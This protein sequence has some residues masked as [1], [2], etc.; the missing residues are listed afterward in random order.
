MANHKSTTSRAVAYYR[1]STQQQE[2]SI[3]QQREWCQPAAVRERLDVV[4]EFADDGVSGSEVEKRPGLMQLVA[5]CEQQHKAKRPVGVILCWDADRLSRASSIRTA[6]LLDDLMGAGVTH[7]FTSEGWIDLEDDADLLVFNVRQDTGRAAYS[8]SVAKNVTRSAIERAG[9]GFW[10]GGK[11]PYGYAVGADGRLAPV[12]PAASVVRRVFA[13]LLAGDSLHE[14]CRALNAGGDPPPGANRKHRD[15]DHKPVWRRDVVGRM[16][17]NRAYVGELVWNRTH[18]GKHQRVRGGRQE[19]TSGQRGESTYAVNAPEDHVAVKDAH[20]ALIDRETFDA[21]AARLRGA[22]WKNAGPSLASEWVF[23]GLVRCGD[24]GSKMYGRTATPHRSRRVAVYRHYVCSAPGTLGTGACRP[25]R[26]PQDM[27]LAAVLHE[28]R[29][30]YSDP[31]RLERLAGAVAE[32]AARADAS[33]GAG[34]DRAEAE[35][36]EI[37][38]QIRQAEENMVFCPT[39]QLHV[40]SRILD[41]LNARRDEL[42]AARDVL[43]DSAADHAADTAGVQEALA[44]LAD[45]GDHLEDVPPR[46]AR[47]VVERLVAKVTVIF[48]HTRPSRSCQASHVDVEFRPELQNLLQSGGGTRQVITVRLPL[49]V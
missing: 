29:A 40:F 34:L 44:A 17:H 2:A 39:H 18:Q 23:S 10:N 25:N 4:K 48:D 28:L 7:I 1:C 33:S 15:P 43:A 36:A 45:L 38:K 31:A 26:T 32:S 8:R 35:L 21:V 13:R 49:S 9:K 37:G 12:E 3:P 6:A 5:F 11:P 30:I 47:R 27:I 19:K 20:P 22:R 42:T 24:C 46:E 14:V 16:V 41:E